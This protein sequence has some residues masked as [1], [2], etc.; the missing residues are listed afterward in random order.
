[1]PINVMVDIE[2]L[3]TAPNATMLTLGA[4][5]FDLGTGEILDTISLRFSLDD[6]SRLNRDISDSTMAWWKKQSDEA[7]AEAFDQTNAEPL[8]DALQKFD[9]WLVATRKADR[10][11]EMRMWANDPDF[12]L[13]IL[14]S[15]FRNVGKEPPW[16]FWESRSVRTMKMIAQEKKITLPDREGTHHN[17]VDDAIH[18]AKVVSAVWIALA[19]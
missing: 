14:T 4:C 11:L 16:Q 2:T 18:Q 17:A 8:S 6:Q 12:D 3:S 7:R 19:A 10:K 9:N 13:V 5:A 1:M 15:A